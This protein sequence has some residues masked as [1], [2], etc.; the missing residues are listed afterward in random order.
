MDALV[1]KVLAKRYLIYFI[2]RAPITAAFS[3]CVTVP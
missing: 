3:R 1:E 2:S